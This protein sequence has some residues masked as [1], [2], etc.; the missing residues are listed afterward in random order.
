[1]FSNTS[2]ALSAYPWLLSLAILLSSFTCSL[3]QAQSKAENQRYNTAIEQAEKAV[4]QGDHK[5]AAEAYRRA[6]SI[7][8][9]DELL[10]LIAQSYRLAGEQRLSLK[11]FQQFVDHAPGDQKVSEAISQIRA[12]QTQLKDQYEEVMITSQPPGAYLY[13]NDRANGSIGQT[14]HRIKLL[15][16]TYQLIAELDG[17]VPAE[18]QLK[19][20][21]GASSQVLITLYSES[22]VAP[23]RFMINR[24]DAQ[25]YVDRRLRGKSPLF[26]PI[27]IRQGVREIRVTKPGFKPWVKQV[28]VVSQTPMTLD[29]MLDEI[30]REEL[31]TKQSS[32]E[33]GMAHWIV[34][35]TGVALLG[36][37]VYTGLSAQ[38]LYSDLET[39]RDQRLLIAEEDITV[40]NRFVLL[41]NIL[42]GLGVTSLT[43]GGVLW[44]LEP[45]APK[46]P[47][48]GA[49]AEGLLGETDS[50]LFTTQ[51]EVMKP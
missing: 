39:R 9:R 26:D 42:L 29:I 40:G 19:L 25:V 41:T 49:R 15:P 5:E 44:A 24:P 34:M 47:A 11:Y 30:G 46:A 4:G 48:P 32:S 36:G 28:N 12:I 27:L 33:G 22:E 13:I 31:S 43:T 21:E 3:A 18:Q 51:V 37:G 35:G 10:F 16:G 14:P 50:T 6:F 38:S 1:M 2:R 20:E 45:S 8:P 7:D 23:V 17:Y